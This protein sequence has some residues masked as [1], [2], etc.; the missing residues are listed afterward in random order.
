MSR[1]ASLAV[2]DVFAGLS[3]NLILSGLGAGGVAAGREEDDRFPL[4][5]T[6]ILFMSVLIL[7]LC[8]E[9]VFPLLGF[10][11]YI[12]LFPASALACHGLEFFFL[13]FQKK[14][15]PA[16]VFDSLTGY[17]GLAGA[18]LFLVRMLASG[19]PEALAL[20][21]GFTL[22][23]MAA[24]LVLVEIRRRSLLEAVPSFLR[25]SPLTLISMGILS[26]ILGS[27]AAVLFKALG[28]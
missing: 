3:F 12:I 4:F 15:S 28:G 21:A 20:A 22:G 14:R 13:T 9:A 19:F 24:M 25:G 8:L 7:W 5:Q 6:G 1:A 16:L 26:L 10:F 11:E 27:T 18:S 2:L 23:V 17:D